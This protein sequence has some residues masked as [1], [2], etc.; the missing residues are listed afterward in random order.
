VKITPL[1][2]RQQQFSYRFRGFDIEE[3]DAFLEM[4]ARELEDQNRENALLREKLT[5]KEEEIQKIRNAVHTL[6][7]QSRE[8]KLL[9]ERLTAKELEVQESRE[10]EKELRKVLA[11]AQQVKEE[12]KGRA[13]KEAELLIKE[14]ELKAEKLLMTAQEQR[15]Q[16]QEDIAELRRQKR[17]F[18]LKLRNMIESHLKLLAFEKEEDQ[19]EQGDRAT[20]P[21]ETLGENLD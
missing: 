5:E 21:E 4:V 20:S 6:E 10:N 8:N 9:R 1:D 2:I 16:I 18:E 7:E 17:L 15:N 12:V 13:E 19:R 3:V 11:T 14:A